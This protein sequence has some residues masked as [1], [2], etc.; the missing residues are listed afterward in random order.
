MG[1]IRGLEQDLF[2]D[3]VAIVFAED[4]SIHLAALMPV[5]VVRQVAVWVP[6]VGAHQV[7]LS[8]AVLKTPG[9][10]DIAGR[11]RNAASAWR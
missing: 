1:F 7:R 10:N 9:V 8:R 11:L 6:Y 5:T 3:L 4:F 2:D